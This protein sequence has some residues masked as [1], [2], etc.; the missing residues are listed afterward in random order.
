LILTGRTVR[1][2]KTE[3]FQLFVW[4]FDMIKARE[5][6]SFSILQL[7]FFEVVVHAIGFQTS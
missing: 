6:I 7:K 2:E 5:N 1:E 4:E 3:S